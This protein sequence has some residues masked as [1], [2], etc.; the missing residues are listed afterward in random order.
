METPT[1]DYERKATVVRFDPPARWR[2]RIAPGFFVCPSLFQKRP[3]TWW[4][5]WQYLFFGFVWE[6]ND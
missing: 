2:L 1:S 4:R 5:L 3:N 6:K